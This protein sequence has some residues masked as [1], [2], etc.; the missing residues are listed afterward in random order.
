MLE[1]WRAPATEVGLEGWLRPVPEEGRQGTGTEAR[2]G[3][4]AQQDRGNLG[5][6]QGFLV[7]TCGTGVHETAVGG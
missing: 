3:S 7:H 4:G 2:G 5:V 6:P 1:S